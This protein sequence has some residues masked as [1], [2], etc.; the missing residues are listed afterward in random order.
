M[1]VLSLSTLYLVAS[2]FGVLRVPGL[3]LT[4]ANL[5]LILLGIACVSV[6]RFGDIRPCV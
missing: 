3:D 4:Y 5:A 1:T 6:G 2:A